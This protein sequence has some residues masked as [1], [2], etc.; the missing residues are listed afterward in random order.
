MPGHTVD[1]GLLSLVL[2]ARFHQVPAD[3]AQLTHLF[4]KTGH[5]FGDTE[6]LRSAKSLKL[7]AKAF[8]ASWE[9]LLKA[10]L[11]AIGR[12]HDGEYFIIAKVADDQVL[13]QRPGSKAPEA[14]PKA[15]F[16]Q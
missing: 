14:L 7:K 15:A 5:V 2:I 10:P 1:S 16:E 12:A 3:P 11:P 13:I 6:I 4:A 8:N 9:S